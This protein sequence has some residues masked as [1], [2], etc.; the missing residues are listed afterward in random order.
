M[1][2]DEAKQFEFAESMMHCS[3]DSTGDWLR[4]ERQELT[5]RVWELEN[6]LTSIFKNAYDG[7]YVYVTA[8]AQLRL[9]DA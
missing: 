7:D 6:A 1:D 4:Q 8:R 2:I 3:T 9:G 5:D